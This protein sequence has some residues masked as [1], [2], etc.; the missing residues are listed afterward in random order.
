VP[1]NLAVVRRAFQL[2]NSRDAEALIAL[3]DPE[4]ELF[5]LA[6]DERRGTGYRGHDGLRQYLRDLDAL[7]ASFA[8]DIDELRKVDDDV[9]FAR[10][11]LRGE[12]RTGRKLD[13]ATSWLWTLRDGVL[14]RM[15]AHPSL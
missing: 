5:P 14:L 3:M 12:M 1:D 15:E 2:F 11:R 4:G 6:V 7:F 9:V 8:V 13:M 10:G